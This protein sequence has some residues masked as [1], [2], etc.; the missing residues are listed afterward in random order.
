MPSYRVEIPGNTPGL[1]T[2]NGH[3]VMVVEAATGADAIVFAQ[4][5][6]GEDAASDGFAVAVATE[7]DVAADMSPF[8]NE[9]GDELAYKI[10]ITVR[11]G[12]VNANFEYTGI[13]GDAI[14]DMW[15]AMVLVCNA[16]AA[17]AGSAF[18]TPLF[19]IS[20]IADGIGD[21]TVTVTF[22]LGGSPTIAS[23]TAAIVHE[24][25][26]GAVLTIATEAAPVI[27]TI[28]PFAA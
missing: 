2:K 26:A 8:D 20:D 9:L 23:Y 7:I 14:A 16:N 21:H 15:D 19:T 22:T 27:P 24:G 12:T 13:A 25:I 28:V 10:L 6:Y 11:G 5:Y 1:T 18:A 3:T 4:G 17:I